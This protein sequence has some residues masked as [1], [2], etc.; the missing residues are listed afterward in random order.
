MLTAIGLL[1]GIAAGHDDL[2]MSGL[3]SFSD[4]CE[5][6][7]SYTG[8]EPRKNQCKYFDGIVDEASMGVQDT[9]GAVR[10]I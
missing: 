7:E 2:G 8:D 6:M 1:I 3:G 4:R 9:H 10:V 5:M